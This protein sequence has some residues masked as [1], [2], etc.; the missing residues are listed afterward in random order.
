[1]S[2]LVTANQ[3]L[4]KLDW[5]R[6]PQIIETRAKEH[7]LSDRLTL[8]TSA[9]CAEIHAQIEELAQE[10]G[11]VLILMGGNA[12]ALRMDVAAQRG[13]RDNDY[14]TT[15]TEE[16]LAQLMRALRDRFRAFPDPFFTY[17]QLKPANA[18]PLP[19]ITYSV[20]VPPLH[21]KNQDRGTIKVKLEFHLSDPGKM[22]ESET[23]EGEFLA[24][25]QLIRARVPLAPHQF[26]LK[27]MVLLPPPIGVEERREDAIPRQ[28]YDLDDLA[29][30]VMDEENWQA[31]QEFAASRYSTECAQHRVAPTAGDP[32]RGV[33][34]RLD[35]WKQCSNTEAGYWSKIQAFQT[36]QIT[37]ATKSRPEEWRARVQRLRLFVRL[38]TLDPSGLA[39]W[40]R[41]LRLEARLG[42]A[43]G[44][45]LRAQRAALGQVVGIP[46]RKVTPQPRST[47]WEFLGEAG[48]IQEALDALD[49][50]LPD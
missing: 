4:F 19:L 3:E 32:W 11:L 23:V 30:R 41:S 22:P 33:L 34:E 37:K 12:A 26:A 38:L 20:Q 49:A 25:G 17:R 10:R 35:E 16:D 9:W 42:P 6:D 45:Q 44:R 2:E 18:L 29:R 7:G 14:L 50:G 1:M 24:V 13:S 40:R 31:L 36:A 8:E 39:A 43:E 46:G 48:D 5:I 47:Y 28:L 21:E 15:A 27:A